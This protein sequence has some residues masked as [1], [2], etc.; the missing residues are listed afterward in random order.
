MTDKELLKKIR[1]SAD[2]VE[3]P[4]SLSPE[5]IHKTLDIS[6]IKANPKHNWHIYPI[7]RTISAAAVLLFCLLLSIVSSKISPNTDSSIETAQRNSS[8][9]EFLM[10]ESIQILDTSQ[11]TAEDSLVIAPKQDAGT[12]Y[13]VAKSYDEVYTYLAALYEE[14]TRYVTSGAILESEEDPPAGDYIAVEESAAESLMEDVSISKSAA[15][16][17]LKYSTT[18]LQTYG[19]DESDRIKTDGKY[20]YTATDSKVRITDVTNEKLT[21]VGTITPNSSATDRILEIYVDNGKLL[22]ITQHYETSM[23]DSSAT[24]SSEDIAYTDMCV[25]IGYSINTKCQTMLYTYD[26]TNPEKPTL[27][28]TF[29]QDGSYY[30]SRKIG[31]ILYLFTNQ[32][33]YTNVAYKEGKN[34]IIPCINNTTIPYENIYLSEQGNAGLVLSSINL[35]TPSEIVDN[36]MI[37]HNYVDI[38]VGPDSIYLYNTDYAQPNS[39]TE[40]AGFSM[41]N[42][43][44]NAIGAAS[45]PGEI[46][47]TFAIHESNRCL[48]ILTTSYD[49]DYLESN[50]LYLL[51]ENMKLTGSL[52]DIAT[53]EIIYSARYFG[54]TV[55]FVTYKNTDPLFVVD[56]SDPAS[57]KMLAELK[58]TGFSEYL[59]FW[60]EDKLLGIGYETDPDTNETLGLKLAMFDISNP[61]KPEVLYTT[62]LTD[63]FYSPALYDYK[64]ILADASANLIGFVGEYENEDYTS[65]YDYFLFSWENDEFI[66][67]MKLPLSDNINHNYLRGIYIQDTFYIASTEEIRSFNR[68]DNYNEIDHLILK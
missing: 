33:V 38:Y 48:R 30:T 25:D 68:K 54:D 20:I 26:I 60:G 34:G 64:C 39:L 40:I 24:Y 55:Y 51:D 49:D 13:T 36:V 42:G 4:E 27:K 58:I 1:N 18:N 15:N 46:L 21:P 22:L 61:T 41:E 28:G 7:Q 63:Y 19:V 35:Q 16:S 32:E 50:N 56:I 8:E 14:E 23:E 43:F 6:S 37:L 59:H 67:K 31:N 53:G 10:E 62:V 3:I 2:A 44:F 9:H 29:I 5:N 17:S 11:A 65:T 45:V 47:D 12:L 52:T 66:Q 57:P